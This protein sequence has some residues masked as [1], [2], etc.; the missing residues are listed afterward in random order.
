[1]SKNEKTTEQKEQLEGKVVTKYDK[2]MQKRQEQKAQ[3]TREKRRNTLISAV[4]VVVLVCLIASFPIRTYLAV[5]ETYV[6][7]GGEDVTK[8]EFDYNYNMVMNNY[9]NQF[10][11]Y[12]T[13]FGLDTTKDLST[14]MYSDTL[15]W[16]DYFEQLAVDNLVESKALMAQA[17]A[18]GFTYDTTEVYNAFKDS[19]KQAAQAQ[20]VTEKKYIQQ[21][22]GSYA[23][24]DRISDYVKQDVITSAYFE[25]VT[26]GKTPSDEEIQAHYDGNKA[27]YDSVDY[28]I[29]TIK[30]ELPTESAQETDTTEATEPSEEEVAK[31]MEAARVQA[32]A[33]LEGIMTEGE[34]MENITRLEA[35]SVIS[36]WLFEDARQA[37]DTTVIEDTASNQY[38]VL[39]FEKR[40]LDQTPSVDVR[41]IIPEEKT[42]EEI[43]EEWKNGAATEESFI[44]LCAQYS[45]DTSSAVE[46]GLYEAL[47]PDSMPEDIATWMFD[48]ARAAGD[49][50]SIT[51]AEDGYTYV[52]YYVG[53]NVPEWKVNIKN[54]LLNNTMTAYLEEIKA[55]ITVED[56]KGKLNYLKVEAQ[57]ATAASE[58]AESAEATESTDVT[59]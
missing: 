8:V 47:V 42:G 22:Y 19:L 18:E 50:V 13:Y 39:G 14:Q 26:E 44:E 11:S 16:K 15:T 10:G 21:L 55:D 30:A 32:D 41:V 43:L 24:M 52:M 17:N 45:T 4:V 58:E 28:R 12:M 7:V 31:A 2:K 27:D 37:G 59:E 33:A 35:A 54:T 20:G 49:T 29:T 46:G 53:Q 3:E 51:S 1:M 40:Y 56:P 9:M 57:E 38:Y 23:N 34:L 6:T 36:T 48:E 25:K 5:N